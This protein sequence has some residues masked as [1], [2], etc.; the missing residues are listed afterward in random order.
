MDI[1]EVVEKVKE[2]MIEDESEIIQDEKIEKYIEAFLKEKNVIK[3]ITCFIAYCKA[4]KT[5]I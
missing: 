2:K 1:K 4:S 3:E 5:E